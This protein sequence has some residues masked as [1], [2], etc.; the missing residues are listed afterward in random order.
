M[1]ILD[2]KPGERPPKDYVGLLRDP[3]Y[4]NVAYLS[5][6]GEIF[7]YH[8]GCQAPHS[9]S[10]W[11]QCECYALLFDPYEETRLDPPL[12]E[13][14]WEKHKENPKLTK[15]FASYFLGKNE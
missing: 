1:K 14:A 5:I 10:L 9:S 7:C 4:S 12:V 2:T 8:K 11:T 6:F 13:K 3:N 15:F